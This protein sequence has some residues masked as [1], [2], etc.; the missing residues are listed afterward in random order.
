MSR[1]PSDLRLFVFGGLVLVVAM[2]VLVLRTHP[3]G[4]RRD[5]GGRSTPAG[6]SVPAPQA[7]IDRTDAPPAG[8]ESPAPRVKAPAVPVQADPEAV[9]PGLRREHDRLLRDRPAF[10]HLP[11]RDTEI[12][13]DFDR[14]VGGGRLELLVTYLGSRARAARDVHRLLARYGDPGTAYVERYQRVF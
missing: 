12:G 9:D 3:S 13:V 1:R 14:V 8:I 5:P 6:S 11:Y 7:T 10:Q 2:S 4:G